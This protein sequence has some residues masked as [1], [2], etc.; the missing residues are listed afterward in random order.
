MQKPIECSECI[1]GKKLPTKDGFIQLGQSFSNFEGKPKFGVH[2]V[3]EALGKHEAQ[4]GL[5]F[6][7]NGESGSLITKIVE[8]L[9]IYD[10]DLNKSRKMRRSDFQWDNIVKCRPPNDELAG[11]SYEREAIENCRIY[12]NRSFGAPNL[13]DSRFNKVIVAL[14]GV[15]FKELTGIS[16]KKLGIEDIRGYVFSSIAYNA[17]IIGALHPSFIR[18]GNSSKT[19]SLIYD[20]KKALLVANG[21]YKSYSAF[22]DFKKPQFIRDGKLDA[23]VSFFYKVKGNPNLTIYYDIE[24]PYTK[25]EEEEDKGDLENE[26]LEDKGKESPFE[27]TSIQLSCGKDWA[28][29][30]PW[31][32][33]FIK[34]ALAI[35]GLENEKVGANVWHHDNPRLEANG[36]KIMGR[37]HDLMWAWHHLQPG[38]WKGLQRI[39]SFFD[40]PHNWKHLALTGNEKDE[41]EYGCMD[42]IAPAYIWPSLVLQMKR[43][44]VWD[45]YLR[46][47]VEYREKVL[48]PTEIRGLPVNIEEHG[49]FKEWV[50]GEV[51][52]E[53]EHLQTGIPE[54]LRNINPKRNVIKDG[55]KYASF[56]YL[57]EPP[58]IKH[59]REAYNLTRD[60]MLSNGVPA[61]SI[62]P[63]ERWA[64]SKSGLSF[65]EFEGDGRGDNSVINGLETVRRWCKVEPFK[66]SSQQLIKYLKFRIAENPKGF[67]YVPK[68]LKEGR[69]TTGKKELQEVWEK[70][71][72]EILG[73]VIRIRSYNK[74][75]SN[76][77]PNWLPDKDGVVRTSFLFDPPSW[78]LNSRHPNIQNASKH[79]K[80]WELIGKTAS[81]LTLIGQRF[82]R[83]VKAPPGRCVVE[84]DKTAFHVSMMGFEAKDPL[85][86]K[87][88]PYM[89]TLFASYI[90]NE[91]IP[92]EGEIDQ[93]KLKYVK[94]KFKNVRDGQAKP[95]VL[96]NQLGLGHIKL[97]YQNRTFID[98][99]GVRQVGIESRRR[100]KYLQDMLGSLFPRIE[101]YKKKIK[102]EA[103]FRKLLKSHYGAIR[104]FHDVLRWDYKTRSWKN[105]SEAEEAQ[106]HNIQADAFGMIHSEFFDM[107][108]NSEIIEEH[109]FANTIHDSGIF[110]PEIG[111]RD[112]CIEEV[113]GFMRK[114]EKVLSDPIC[115]PEGL[116][117]DVE[118][119]GS[120]EGG[121]WANWHKERNPGGI[122]EIKI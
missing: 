52:V 102:E 35:L 6:R 115:A 69:E 64:E 109:W 47:K 37:I 32:K 45:S 11:K 49:K 42:V 61:T 51:R 48:K 122:Q 62:V 53:D 34:V 81:E 108:E 3:G 18:H 59:L 10:P 43:I 16:G 39:G 38:L 72:D 82:R 31:E 54:C 110:F 9:V 95:A 96:G 77:L 116:M 8:D 103:H 56:G 94:K 106:S 40:V 36:A 113:V 98:E 85:Y 90:V 60:K 67:Y 4:E 29:N 7:P 26:D 100:A 117:V 33:P 91:P 23:L 44:G 74:M 76:D 46:F 101:E 66:S 28:I 105:G 118:V 78:Q 107:A 12:D 19:P 97:H 84:F 15:A 86:I 87:W 25:G 88:A 104:W 93:D 75:L 41:D 27:I 73:S 2:V 17:L 30:V 5:P 114:K 22:A 65:R 71:G 119:M 70:T 79:P 112:R 50:E 55:K 13:F 99:N 121:N 58:E 83:I 92:I 24:N 20:I 89:H 14:G 80:E 57:R 1:L 21:S 120:C 111:K 63:F 68:T